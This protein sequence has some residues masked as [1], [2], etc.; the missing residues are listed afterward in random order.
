MS[1][2]P[3][4]SLIAGSFLLGAMLFF[5]SVTAPAIFKF[6][7]EDARPPILRGIFPRYYSWC[8]IVTLLA[9]GLSLSAINEPTIIF[10]AITFGF[11]FL[12]YGLIP[13]I[14]KLR[15]LR[16]TGD[17]TARIQFAKLH[18]LSV[19]INLAQMVATIWVMALI[20]QIGV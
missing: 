17:E 12:R 9:T 2:L 4:L 13:K 18:R 20:V 1:L 8:A 3:T 19:F 5:A 10:A 7:P 6:L 16:T 11:I 15:E 14:E